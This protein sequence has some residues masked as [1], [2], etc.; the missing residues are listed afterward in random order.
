MQSGPSRSRGSRN[1]IKKD[2]K[3]PTVGNL[4]LGSVAVQSGKQEPA[5]AN[6]EP[7]RQRNY[8]GTS[9]RPSPA[10]RPSLLLSLPLTLLPEKAL[11]RMYLPLSY[12]LCCC[13]PPTVAEKRIDGCSPFSSGNTLSFANRGGWGRVERTRERELGEDGVKRLPG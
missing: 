8:A 6:A 1:P 13:Y 9:S 5:A 10:S 12:I 2:K 4:E 11:R 3:K 7:I